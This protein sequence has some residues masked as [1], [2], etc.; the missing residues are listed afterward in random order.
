[1]LHLLPVR[2]VLSLIIVLIALIVRAVVYA[3]MLDTGNDVKD[4]MTVIRY[5]SIGTAFLFTAP[6]VLWRWVPPLQRITFPYLGG[7][8]TGELNFQGARGYGTREVN[9]HINHSFLKIKLV[10]DSSE[11]TSRTLLVHPERDV[12]INRNRLYYVYLNERKEG[13][14]GAGER[15]RGLAVLRVEMSPR[16]TLHGDY[17]TET[18]SSGTLAM[19]LK[20]SHPWWAIWK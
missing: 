14:A 6:Y 17:F 9:L 12:D 16:P 3:G 11:S 15:Y 19:Q 18:R 1:M 8:W 10:L 20:Q 5:S 7:K 2:I 4:V 13:V